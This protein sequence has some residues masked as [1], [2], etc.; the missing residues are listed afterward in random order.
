M[1][2]QG[3]YQVTTS[4]INPESIPPHEFV[5]MSYNVDSYYRTGE[6][7][8]RRERETDTNYIERKRSVISPP[9]IRKAIESVNSVV[10]GEPATRTF[11][12]DNDEDIKESDS[13]VFDFI[14]NADLQNGTLDSVVGEAA[15][16]SKLNKVC[17]IVVDNFD[18]DVLQVYPTL[19][20]QKDNRIYPY[21]Y[22]RRITQT[23]QDE[24][25]YDKYGRLQKI[26]FIEHEAMC[27]YGCNLSINCDGNLAQY[28][29]ESKRTHN[30]YRTWTKDETYLC[31]Y[32]DINRKHECIILTDTIKKLN[33]GV[34][35]VVS[36]W[37]GK[38]DDITSI[39]VD[40]PYYPLCR[41][42]LAI[43]NKISDLSMVEDRNQYSML[44]MTTPND[45]SK[46]IIVGPANVIGVPKDGITPE[47]ISPDSS[48]IDIAR[49]GI[50]ERIDNLYTM[51]NSDNNVEGVVAQRSGIAA[52]WSHTALEQNV[53]KWATIANTT[54]TLVL[55]IYRRYVNENWKSGTEYHDTIQPNNT[56]TI[57]NNTEKLVSDTYKF[58]YSEFSKNE[59]RKR[60]LVELTQDSLPK[61]TID[62]MLKAE[63]DNLDKVTEENDVTE[64]PSN[65][66]NIDD[67]DE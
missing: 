50:K 67:I 52:Q 17:F 55:D 8:Q 62:D 40:P 18:D 45:T 20:Q 12:D 33:L 57:I 37:S 47:W 39:Y 16:W 65:D 66:E 28:D 23:K 9:I 34:I 56:E 3:T 15:I 6:I 46:G 58:G 25:V 60:L 5:E 53:K 27:T 24:V 30:I 44:A 32:K 59:I 43:Y 54:D 41:E 4:T 1:T 49:K 2:I 14:Q 35:P 26:V 48:V 29:E 21:A 42:Y 19:E 63:D 11:K 61:E 7:L 13:T 31:Y 22:T 38:R 51:A 36:M 64:E 10:F